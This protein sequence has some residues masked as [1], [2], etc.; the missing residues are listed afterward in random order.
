MDFNVD[1]MTAT[2]WHFDGASLTGFDEI[3]LPQN[4][5]TKKMCD[6]LKARGYR[7]DVTSIYPDPASKARS[8]KGLP[9]VTILRNEGFTDI[10]VRLQAPT[11]RKRQLNM[12]NLLA[13]G[14][15]K[16]NPDK[17]PTFKRDM[18]G[19]AQDP[20][21]L[22]KDKSNPRLTH[23]SD[24]VDYMTDILFPLSGEKPQRSEIVR[25]R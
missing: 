22:E 14:V 17:M 18:A 9:D 6:A 8:T 19:V 5:D 3:V 13:K 10:K 20:V 15:I 7:P 25:F 2:C 1:F 16:F 24:G 12:N 4:A 21:T 23:A 11:F